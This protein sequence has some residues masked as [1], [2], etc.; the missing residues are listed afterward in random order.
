MSQELPN[1][2]RLGI[3]GN[4]EIS[5]KSQLKFSRNVQFHMKTEIC[6]KYFVNNCRLTGNGEGLV[7]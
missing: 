6:L 5:G 3:L 1:E 4:K 7:L 2:L